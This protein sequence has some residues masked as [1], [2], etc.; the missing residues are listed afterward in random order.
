MDATNEL[1][2]EFQSEA[3]EIAGQSLEILESIEG[4][5]SQR[6]RL[7]DYGLLVDRVMG[8]AKSLALVTPELKDTLNIIGAYTEL[9][10]QVSY[11]CSRIDNNENLYNIVVALLLD[12]T[13]MLERMITAIKKESALDIKSF[14]T[15]TFLDRLRW[16]S[17]QFSPDASGTV[18]HG[19]GDPQAQAQIEHLLKSLGI[20][21]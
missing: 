6:K 18:S 1:I 10:K 15:T 12:A 14:L 21:S 16:I 11:K 5:Y 13:E 20:K 2:S 17:K 3:K 8:A 19:G 4:D 7:Q 9:C